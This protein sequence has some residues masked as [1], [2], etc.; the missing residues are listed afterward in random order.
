MIYYNRVNFL[1]FAW[2]CKTRK[3]ASVDTDEKFI[4]RS[5]AIYKKG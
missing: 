4:A 3:M 1:K 5:F 2:L